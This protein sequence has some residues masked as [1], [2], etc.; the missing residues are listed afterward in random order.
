MVNDLN[1]DSCPHLWR[2]LKND[3]NIRTVIDIG[4]HDGAFAEFLATCFA[5]EAVFAIEPLE[6]CQPHLKARSDRIPGFQVF[7]VALSDNAGES[8]LFENAH[9]PS[10]SLLS[11]SETMSMEFPFTVTTN[12]AKVQLARLDALLDPSRLHR[13]ILIKI[14]VQGMEDKVIAGGKKVF[15]TAK[16]VYIEMSFVELYEKQPC[17]HEVHALLSSLG[18][19]LAGIKNQICSQKEGRPLFAHCVY[20][21]V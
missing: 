15:S 6:A 21:R 13:D 12:P 16:A 8:V 1:F 2:W 5:P 10:S 3:L 7:N 11:V 20:L 17:F 4:A 18:F 9:T 14:D 19:R